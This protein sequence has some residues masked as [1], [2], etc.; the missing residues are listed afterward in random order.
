MKPSEPPVARSI[1]DDYA[2]ETEHAPRIHTI[3]LVIP[4]VVFGAWIVLLAWMACRRWFGS[5]L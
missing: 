2:W 4:A 3:W 5:L 1:G